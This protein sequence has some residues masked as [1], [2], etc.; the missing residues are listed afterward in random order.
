MHSTQ[1]P[2][3]PSQGTLYPQGLP[4]GVFHKRAPANAFAARRQVVC[5]RIDVSKDLYA[6]LH[7]V[8][9][10]D[11]P[12]KRVS[13]SLETVSRGQGAWDV[14]G[15]DM[16]SPE[17]PP[18]NTSAATNGCE[19]ILSA[20]LASGTSL[21]VVIP[22]FWPSF[23]VVLDPKRWGCPDTRKGDSALASRVRR[24]I[25]DVLRAQ[26][27]KCDQ[28]FR[29]SIEDKFS[30]M[31]GYEMSPVNPARRRKVW[32]VRISCSSVNMMRR[33]VRALNDAPK[34][35]GL[36][37]EEHRRLSPEFKF[38]D[39]R[40]LP[41]NSWFVIPRRTY[42]VLEENDPTP[43]LRTR[44]VEVQIQNILGLER[45]KQASGPGR[46]DDAPD[47]NYIPP[48]LFAYADIEARSQSLEEF[49]DP[50]KPNAPCYIVGVSFA[51]AFDLPPCFRRP[52]PHEGVLAEEE[53]S[54]S[55][56]KTAQIES[57]LSETARARTER[58]ELR[59]ERLKRYTG[60]KYIEDVF[61]ED[62]GGVADLNSDDE[63]DGTERENEKA[64]ESVLS[65][66]KEQ[67]ERGRAQAQTYAW[68]RDMGEAMW[69]SGPA[70]SLADVERR[71]SRGIVQEYPF[72]RVLLVLGSCDPI[73]G[74]VVI[75]FDTEKELLKYLRVLLAGLMDVDGIRGYNWLNFDSTY[76]VRRSEFHGIQ[77]DVLRLTHIPDHLVYDAEPYALALQTG[78]FLITRMPGT[79]TIDM[80]AFMRQNYRLSSYKLENIAHNFGLKGKHP[81]GIDH[82]YYGFDGSAAE[83][84]VIAAY[85]AQDCDLLIHV[86]RRSKFEVTLTQ[87]ARIMLTPA[88][89]MWSSGQQIR[90]LHQIVWTAHR[91]AFIVDQI[92]VKHPD[93]ALT[94]LPSGK[95][96]DGGFV[97]D[98]LR[99]HYT[100]PTAT[101]DYKSLYPS[102]MIGYTLCPTTAILGP[103]DKASEIADQIREA[104][105]E[106]VRV[107]TSG[108][109]FHWIQHERNLIPTIL[110]KLWDERQATKKLEKK[111]SG[112]LKIVHNKKQLAI[113]VSMNSFFGGQGAEHG[114][115]EMLR[116]AHTIT[117][118]GRTTVQKAAQYANHLHSAKWKVGDEMVDLLERTD[119]EL[120]REPDARNQPLTVYG[121]T[122]SIMVNMPRPNQGF[123]KALRQS[124][125]ADPEL[126]IM[127]HD[128]SAPATVSETLL[129]T[130]ALAEFIAEK[131][132]ATYR[133][134]IELEF[135]EVA[136]QAN[137]LQ[138][139]MYVKCLLEGISDDDLRHAALG[140]PVGTLK[141]SGIS[142]VR[143]DRAAYV[144]KLQKDVATA[145]IME[146]NESRAMQ[147]VRRRLFRLALGEVRFED[148]ITTTELKNETPDI[149]RSPPPPHVAVSWAI[150][151]LHP[152]MQ[153]KRGDRVAWLASKHADLSRLLPPARLLPMYP[154][155]VR[156][157]KLDSRKRP[158]TLKEQAKA[159]DAED[160]RLLR[161]RNEFL[162]RR[163]ACRSVYARHVSE[164]DPATFAKK[165]MDRSEYLKS[166]LA[167]LEILFATRPDLLS[168]VQRFGSDAEKLSKGQIIFRG[169]FKKQKA[170]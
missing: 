40:S 127:V 150:E 164:V 44:V 72:L 118:V 14:D 114:I 58:R 4:S 8:T 62:S 95:R 20:T 111:A 82:I 65:D 154:H 90:L 67:L 17:N 43:S 38:M 28:H 41:P 78:R 124:S 155:L 149:Q 132:N 73:E 166:A 159:L 76:L 1:R 21:A 148:L 101:L 87:F 151:R 138:P 66:A 80:Y 168:Q 126:G 93:P 119:E 153:P 32:S 33:A 68:P 54:V 131:L 100:T 10:Y 89:L 29:F 104:G 135:E 102:I 137:F 77:K 24:A 99:G 121:D 145:F 57:K 79:N 16:I 106:V 158:R 144:R 49:P 115:Y 19:V 86:A 146:Q 15:V 116:A 35:Q 92:G 105:I 143:R 109:S 30:R 22:N 147:L 12:R 45:A 98:P 156:L 36:L 128:A 139:K 18:D 60:K 103:V 81:I 48:T 64:L 52:S 6:Y 107:D 27:Y 47:E 75:T 123:L 140:K 61:T 59:T 23:R 170:T 162:E 46:F 50:T 7:Q 141:A 83:R 122:D 56:W 125:R 97:M 152:G 9:V 11:T 130:E 63:S 70:W 113:K 133:K 117:H 84:A 85:C 120:T 2:V 96:F 94:Q 71:E 88:E 160:R 112:S 110:R 69:R 136:I 25:F 26:I 53:Q 37:A 3:F 169:F 167:Q 74:A 91:S 165:G 34:T 108:G 51:W 163:K 157:Q 134:P 55:E 161:E 31:Y 42:R 129:Y 142:A 5:E 13:F 39:D